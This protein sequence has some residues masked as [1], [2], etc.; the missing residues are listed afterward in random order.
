[1]CGGA[2]WYAMAQGANFVSSSR[3]M[4]QPMIIGKLF[5]C[6]LRACGKSFFVTVYWGAIW[7]IGTNNETKKNVNV[8]ARKSS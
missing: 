4:Q 1:M 6:C 8:A 5:K 7:G 3:F 2:R